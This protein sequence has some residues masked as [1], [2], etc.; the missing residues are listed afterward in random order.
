VSAVRLA[1]ANGLS[2][3]AMVRVGQQLIVPEP[4]VAPSEEKPAA[5]PATAPPSRVTHKVRSGETLS[6]IARKYGTTVA[7][8]TSENGL[9]KKTTLQP[10]RTLVI[11]SK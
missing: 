4:E 7:A 3:K 1:R 5:P 11:P 6:S 2:Q 8:L 9:D 10:G